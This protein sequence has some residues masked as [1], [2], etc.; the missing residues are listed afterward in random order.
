[1]KPK[2][3]KENFFGVKNPD[4]WTQECPAVFQLCYGFMVG[5][6]QI[7]RYFKKDYGAVLLLFKKDYGAHYL[8]KKK[9]IELAESVFSD[10]V[11]NPRPLDK[12]VSR[13]QPLRRRLLSAQRATERANLRKTEN[14]ILYK[15]YNNL[16]SA[17]IEE[18]TPAMVVE[19]FEPYTTDVFYPKL[20]SFSKE[21]KQHLKLLEQ[22]TFK[23]FITSHQTELLRLA[24]AAGRDNSLRAALLDGRP[25]EEKLESL[26]FSNLRFYKLLI[27]C[28][29]KY[30]WLSN[31]YR[32]DIVL[33]PAHFLNLIIAELK[34]KNVDQI[35][36]EI[37][38]ISASVAKLKKEKIKARKNLIKIG[39][40][41]DI[42]A[43]YELL[44]KIGPWHDER[45]RLMLLSSHY[46][47]MLLGEIGR[48]FGYSLFEMHYFQP[49]EIKA[50]LLN[51]KKIDKRVLVGRRDI[52]VWI[53]AKGKEYLFSG[54][55]AKDIMQT[56]EGGRNLALHE[57][58]T[59]LPA[60]AG[61]VQGKVRIVL[62]A[63]DN[64]FKDGEV[65]VTT[66]TRPEFVPL[67][68][69]A[70]AIV[71]DEGGLTCHAAIISR[72]LGIPCVVGTRTATRELEDGDLVEVRAHR[73]EI[74]V[75]T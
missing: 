10:F 71:T 63:Q 11:K 22:A 59:G 18:Y 23:S 2:I 61:V 4:W 68:K 73:G 27:E 69:R 65:L 30:F 12:I 16:L 35:K 41:R 60:A 53:S 46:M 34:D 13:W 6:A 54:K 28:Q 42:P 15:L 14:K 26:E 24:L 19:A 20:A 39:I 3:S 52:C 45:K 36:A 48:R 21:I 67:M 32:D 51:N 50:L 62:D 58:I 17:Y 7:G 38:K 64:Q 5:F 47:T 56:V 70:V 29:R 75:L 57:V 31:N 33:S 25:T 43:F 9:T 40:P 49:Q 66:M 55:E 44:E 37:V 1:M 8:D 72:E 74:K